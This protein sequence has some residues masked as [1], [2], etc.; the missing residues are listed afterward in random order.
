MQFDFCANTA[1]L[2]EGERGAI[3]DTYLREVRGPATDLITSILLDPARRTEENKQRLLELV[4]RAHQLALRVQPSW[5]LE[6]R[7]R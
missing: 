2:P 3:L 4:D 5:P 1:R 6:Y 7:E